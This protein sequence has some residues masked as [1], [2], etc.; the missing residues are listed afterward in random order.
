M[1][2]LTRAAAHLRLASGRAVGQNVQQ[3]RG[4]GGSAHH[5]NPE[6]YVTYAGL[7]LKKAPGWEYALSK[8]I[9]G[10]M[11]FWVFTMC[12]KEWD[13]KTKGLP[14]IFE[15]EGLDDDAHGHGHH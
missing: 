10:T 14:A 15:A 1:S 9:G 11:W 8:V 7:K 3:T 4:M 13:H 5:G 12:Y 2:L 6:D